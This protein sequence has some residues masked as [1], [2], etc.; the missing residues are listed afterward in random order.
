MSD[1]ATGTA[2]EGEFVSISRRDLELLARA[3][4]LTSQ[5]FGWGQVDLDDIDSFGLASSREPTADERDDD[6]DV[7]EIVELSDAFEDAVDRACDALG[8]NRA[9]IGTQYD[10]MRRSA[11]AEPVPELI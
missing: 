4:D 2:P 11:I 7:D 9:D 5:A 6:P 3:G 10:P 8:L 1:A